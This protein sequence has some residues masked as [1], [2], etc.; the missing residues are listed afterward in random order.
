VEVA[1]F[2]LSFEEA[3]LEAIIAGGTRF[4]K[5]GYTHKL[6]GKKDK[7]VEIARKIINAVYRILAADHRQKL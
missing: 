7:A 1:C 5:S 6:G 4:P 2:N 3:L